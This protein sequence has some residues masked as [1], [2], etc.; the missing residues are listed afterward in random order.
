[1]LDELIIALEQ[2]TNP[3]MVF[4]VLKPKLWNLY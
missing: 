3:D 2:L 1:M 4:K